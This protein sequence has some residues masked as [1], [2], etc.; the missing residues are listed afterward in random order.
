[1]KD[2]DELGRPVTAPNKEIVSREKA[3]CRCAEEC[4]LA[5]EENSVMLQRSPSVLTSSLV[6]SEMIVSMTT[7]AVRKHRVSRE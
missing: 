6:A 4:S 2:S 7:S 3:A 5:G 1:M